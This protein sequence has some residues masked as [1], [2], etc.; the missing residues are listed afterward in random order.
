MLEKVNII[1][2]FGKS[3]REE[4]KELVKDLVEK[5]INGK[6]DAYLKKVFAR[7]IDAEVT[8][9]YTITYHEESKKYDA[10]FIL[11]YDGYD[12]IYQQEGFSILSDLVNHAFKRFKEKL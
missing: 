1:P 3:V 8:L 10:D 9:K 7:K 5:N 11:S 12:A 6:M 4:D 2:R